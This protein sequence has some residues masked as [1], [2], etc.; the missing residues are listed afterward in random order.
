MTRRPCSCLSLSEPSC[1]LATSVAGGSL[2]CRKRDLA[3]QLQN[4][5]SWLFVCSP[6]R[7]LSAPGPCRPA[8]RP[9]HIAH[10]T[11]HPGPQPAPPAESILVLGPAHNLY[12]YMWRILSLN[13]KMFNKNRDSFLAT[14][15]KSAAHFMTLGK[16]TSYHAPVIEP[17]KS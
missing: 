13:S 12:L 16:M 8:R 5:A 4:S 15:G 14:E 10:V 17:L 11:G 3:L 6:R 2:C 7:P 1:V 9:Q